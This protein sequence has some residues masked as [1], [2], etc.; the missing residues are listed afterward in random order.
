MERGARTE[1]KKDGL[2]RR[3]RM[4]DSVEKCARVHKDPLLWSRKE[5]KT[6]FSECVP[7][8][9]VVEMS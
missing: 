6:S 9:C 7:R 1:R 4:I 8:R 2:Q 5:L 3:S